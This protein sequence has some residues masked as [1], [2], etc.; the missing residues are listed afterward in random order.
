MQIIEK[1]EKDIASFQSG[2]V[3]IYS[4]Y[5]CTPSPIGDCE[6]L[7]ERK[8]KEQEKGRS[9]GWREERNGEREKDTS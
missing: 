9:A 7:C 8:E 5:L 2:N 6:I 3:E 1:L 4:S